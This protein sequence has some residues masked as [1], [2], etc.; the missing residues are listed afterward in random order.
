VSSV[1]S[2]EPEGA[3]PLDEEDLRGLLRTDI[4]LRHELNLAEAQN[5][6]SGQL[7][8][9]AR[10]RPPLRW[11]TEAEL[12]TLH[13]RMFGDVWRWAGTFRRRETNI[14]VA[15]YSIAAELRSLLLDVQAQTADPSSLAWPADE[16]AVRFHHRLVAIHPFP[17]GNGRHARLA[18]DVLAVGLGQP[19]FTW[20]QAGYLTES[21][22]ARG[23]YLEALRTADREYRYDLLLAFARS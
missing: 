6:A 18:A 14:G 15:P 11:L 3:T 7:W 1:G 22:T 21:S 10:R 17:N 20:G 9:F 5:I 4:A 2:D 13:R 8:A 19:S 23:L 12:K 16:I